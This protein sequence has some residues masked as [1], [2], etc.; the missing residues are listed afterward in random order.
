MV[1]ST[2]S[3]ASLNLSVRVPMNGPSGP[4]NG[5]QY[6]NSTLEQPSGRVMPLPVVPPVVAVASVAAPPVVAVAAGDAVSPPHAASSMPNML[7]R[8][9]CVNPFRNLND[10]SISSLVY[11]Q[12][13]SPAYCTGEVNSIYDP[14]STSLV[15]PPF[16]PRPMW[17]AKQIV[18]SC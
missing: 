1:T 16:T 12:N 9:A 3:F 18:L 13:C 8:I 7:T 4:V 17:R 14:R 5:F 6:D 10:I 2:L 11:S 15:I